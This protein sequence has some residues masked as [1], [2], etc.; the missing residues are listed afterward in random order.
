MSSKKCILFLIAN[1][2]KKGLGSELL[3]LI[4][5]WHNHNIYDFIKINISSFIESFEF[6]Q[7]NWFKLIK[8][9][10]RAGRGVNVGTGPEGGK[11]RNRTSLKIEKILLYFLHLININVSKI[12]NFLKLITTQLLSQV[13]L[14]FMEAILNGEKLVKKFLNKKQWNGVY[15]L[16][17]MC[18]SWTIIKK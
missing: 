12:V 18:G 6:D 8:K 3:S 15:I 5:V 2:A 14:I 13:C 11:C 7:L 9:T 1:I 10:I 4:N 16:W 17:P